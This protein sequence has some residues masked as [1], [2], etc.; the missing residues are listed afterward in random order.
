MV[1]F[2]SLENVQP[3]P[4][5]FNP[6]DEMLLNDLTLNF[7]P[8]TISILKN[9]FKE[10]NGEMDM[11]DFIMIIKDHL[12]HWQL[13]IPNREK[14]LIRCLSLLFYDIDL[15]GN[16]N[17]EWDEFT[18]YIIEKAAVLNTMKNKN[19]EIKSYHSSNLK[20]NMKFSQPIAKCI[21]I[22]I[23]DKIAFFEEGS[24]E[25]HFADPKTGQI[26][27]DRSLVVRISTQTKKSDG[28][29]IP[30][31][32]ADRAM[33]LDM[34]FVEDKK[35]ELLITSSN[36]GVIR[37]FRYSSNGFVPADD[38][39]QRDH[40]IV[41]ENAQICITWDNIDEILYSGQRNGVIKI[42]D[43]KSEPQFS[44]LGGK[45]QK[46]SLNKQRSYSRS[47]TSNSDSMSSRS[48]QQRFRAKKTGKKDGGDNFHSDVITCLL[49]LNKLQF[50]ASASLDRKIILWDTIE[51][52]K[53]REYKNY[54]RKGIVA[55]D[56]NE[57]LILLISGGFDHEIFVWNPYIDS[58]VHNLSGH[59]APIVSIRFVDNPMHIVSLDTDMTIKIWDSKKFMC[60]DT[61]NVEEFEEKKNFNPNGICILTNPL[62]LIVIGKT[63][64]F[65][66]YDRNNNLTSADE[67][68]SI[69]AKFIPSNLTLLTP[70]G[71]KIK[72]WNLLT[73]EVKRIFSNLSKTDIS[74]CNLD[75]RAKRFMV[76]DLEGNVGVYNVNNGAQLK[77]L[78]K[79][80]NEVISIIHSEQLEYI[81]SASI[82]NEIKI[83]DDRE[84]ADSDLLRTLEIGNFH[85]SS[86]T[87]NHDLGKII[88]GGNNGTI[89]IFEAATGKG[90]E[91]FQDQ[92]VQGTDEE[93]ACIEFIK[94][95]SCM[96]YANNMG[97]IKVMGLPP[98]VVKHSKLCQF[99][100]TSK[101]IE[102]GKEKLKPMGVV[103]ILFCEEHGKLYVADEK[104]M[105]KCYDILPL[106]GIC[107]NKLANTQ[108]K[109]RKDP[110]IPEGWLS[111]V[112]Q[113]HVHEDVIKSMSYIPS[114]NLIVTTCMSK[115]VKITNSV[116]GH[117][118]ESLRQQKNP[119]LIK[120]IAYK[121]VESDEIYSPRMIHRV[122]RK[123]MLYFRE[124]EQKKLDQQR[125]LEQGYLPSSNPQAEF[126]KKL[127]EDMVQVDAFKEYEEQEF[128]PFYYEDK[129][130]RSWADTKKSNHWK[131]YLNFE[132]YWNQFEDN[133]EQ[134]WAD[135]RKG[136]KE[137][138]QQVNRYKAGN[139]VDSLARQKLNEVK[140]LQSY[141]DELAA[142][143]VKKV[144]KFKKGLDGDHETDSKQGSSS[145]KKQQKQK[146]VTLE[147]HKRIVKYNQKFV[148]VT[149]EKEAE[150]LKKMQ[151]QQEK[152][153]KKARSKL[154]QNLY[155]KGLKKEM[156]KKMKFEDKKMKLSQSEINAAERLAAALTNYDEDDPR[157]LMFAD[158]ELRAGCGGKSK[159]KRGSKAGSSKYSSSSKR[160][161]RM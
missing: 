127:K 44:Q 152:K 28:I 67:N 161:R 150:L 12:I 2:P 59:A 48:T 77:T 81:I 47:I 121:K 42:W 130:D 37:M 123:Y 23:I 8:F 133:T 88:V 128:D 64:S 45:Q 6:V 148:S 60:S 157:S 56:F 126:E 75:S 118:I 141:Q 95:H 114:E 17:M 110:V 58:P 65:L 55:L 91:E 79:H 93:V 3:L 112:W 63:L 149:A 26:M 21:Y 4:A 29:N 145:G 14:K 62:K 66:E 18:N 70:V 84:L 7:D 53:K 46:A 119:H 99:Q 11:T 111:L 24:D 159:S 107:K 155:K 158:Y 5:N 136:E 97:M 82:D 135:V 132:K 83:H 30:N 71:N 116:N 50:L 106:L 103:E 38:S 74:S 1:R 143:R 39:N 69:C 117:Q 134:I 156:M 108:D 80:K 125:R 139:E 151:D 105:V 100:N 147:G 96:I 102:E 33:L 19:E 138:D 104:Y 25:I 131:L 146:S 98:L 15:N 137:L 90:N 10:R 86:I 129:I 36:D 160:K 124:R 78:N 153:K 49:P 72:V 20:V 51:N 120:P 113:K 122:D 43:Q 73:G 9:E 76:G 101:V 31:Y 142:E 32:N 22:S 144:E 16:G 54:H 94:G 109:S 140:N 13:D 35:Y 115:Q 61:M 154:Y 85:I 89:G 40:E 27:Q 52:K 92:S 57:N 87:F 41:Y 34:I 68:V